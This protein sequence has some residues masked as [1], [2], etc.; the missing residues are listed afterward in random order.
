MSNP[1]IAHL[2]FCAFHTVSKSSLV[3]VKGI[4]LSIALDLA[5]SQRACKTFSSLTSLS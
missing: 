2:P 4:D 1:E 5:A 3:I